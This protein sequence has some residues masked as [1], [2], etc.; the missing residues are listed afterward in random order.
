MK[1]IKV[2]G[3]SK[4]GK[5]TTVA[6]IIRELR[7]RGYTVGSVKEIHFE[8]FTMETAGSNT[9]IHKK[10]GA[11]PVTARGLAETDIM[12]D[13]RIDID[14]LLDMYDRDYVVIEGKCEANCPSI[15][16]AKTAEQLDEQI[17]PLTIACAGV[18]SN[19]I[20]EYRGLPVINALDDA[21]RLVDLIE[22]KT[23]ERMPNYD[24]DCCTACGTDC[25]GLTERIIRGTGSISECILKGQSVQ[26]F[27]NGE[28]LPMVPFVKSM[29]RSVSTS[30]IKELDGYE[31]NAEIVIRI[32][33]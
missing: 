4:T 9:D 29:V 33:N 27:I 11:N 1:V 18:I 23:P 30:V 26:V 22:A 32:K 20:T 13:S 15:A 17:T 28:E 24:A 16:T 21:E 10:A 5:T 19:D 6:A 8:R 14:K 12:L 7:R 2:Q 25:R 3:T 31:E